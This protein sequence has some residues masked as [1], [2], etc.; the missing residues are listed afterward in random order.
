MGDIKLVSWDVYGTLIASGN[1]EVSDVE[2]MEKIR[3]RPG[4]LEILTELNSQKITQCT[5]SDGNLTE[6]KK[7]LVSVGINWLDFF[8]DLYQMPRG[9]LKD[10]SYIIEFHRI[11]SENLLVI[12]DNYDYDLMLAKKQGCKIL[13]VP[14]REN[15]L[16]P[17]PVNELIDLI[18]NK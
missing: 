16:T 8:Y 13:H 11:N 18:K 10:F 17:F 9:E 5:C 15:F 3:L 14:E 1:N 7:N 6:L 4:V 12:G 2:E